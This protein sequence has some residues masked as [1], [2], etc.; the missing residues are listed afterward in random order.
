MNKKV[1][2]RKKVISFISTLALLSSAQ[3]STSMPRAMDAG[4]GIAIVEVKE[5]DP[6]PLLADILKDPNKQKACLYAKNNKGIPGKKD[7]LSVEGVKANAQLALYKLL[8]N[9]GNDNPLPGKWQNDKTLTLLPNGILATKDVVPLV[10]K[11][12]AK[13]GGMSADVELE[14][15]SQNNNNIGGTNYFEQIET[16]FNMIV[17]PGTMRF[18]WVDTVSQTDAIY[19]VKVIPSY[20]GYPVDNSGSNPTHYTMKNGKNVVSDAS[21]NALCVDS[22]TWDGNHLQSVK[23]K[24]AGDTDAPV[25][26][27]RP[28]LFKLQKYVA[29]LPPVEYPI[30][31]NPSPVYTPPSPTTSSPSSEKGL[32]PASKAVIS[33]AVIGGTATL[34]GG[35]VAIARSRKASPQRTQTKLSRSPKSTQ[36]GGNVKNPKKPLPQGVKK[37]SKPNV[38]N[39]ATPNLKTIKR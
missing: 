37:P 7:A 38:T 36:T 16:N 22:C 13:A 5:D 21:G 27:A 4:G 20:V 18:L 24:V 9:N 33:I 35:T 23:W 2:L 11:W 19:T 31:P 26:V 1:N 8:S 6:Y 12:S 34:A 32:S 28:D 15:L 29:P 14:I 25:V 10:F 39:Q 17:N 30:V 3:L